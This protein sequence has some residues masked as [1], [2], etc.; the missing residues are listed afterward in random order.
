MGHKVSV[1]IAVATVTSSPTVVE[2]FITPSSPKPNSGIVDMSVVFSKIKLPSM[3]KIT[4]K[5]QPEKR[6]KNID[7]L[8]F[9]KRVE[10][11]ELFVRHR[12]L[13]RRKRRLR[14]VLRTQS[15]DGDHV[16]RTGKIKKW[17]RLDTTH[18][19]ISAA[20][21][22]QSA[23]A[24]DVA[25]L[26][27]MFGTN[28]NMLWGDLDN[29][30]ARR[31]YHT[32]L[33]RLLMGLYAQGLTTPD[34]LAP[35][36]YEAR[37][38]AK[39]YTRERS[40]VPG[41]VWA[42]AYDGFRHLKTYGNWSGNGLSWEELW[43]K[44]EDEVLEELQEGLS[45]LDNDEVDL[46]N[47]VCL[48]ILERSCITNSQIDDRF[49]KQNG[50][51]VTYGKKNPEEELLAI[52]SRFEKDINNLLE[53]N[54]EFQKETLSP[55]DFFFLRLFKRKLLMLRQHKDTSLSNN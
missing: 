41:R 22:R 55:R 2:S 28:R 32:L 12:E 50:D 4:R 26:R 51:P 16:A 6:K 27:S 5:E 45:D 14:D 53:R 23:C 7:I 25:T 35:L 30:T 44:Y 49:L 31:L 9:R 15:E 17:R 48:K 46:S 52:A 39:Q 43:V 21:L 40:Q 54:G 11:R 20:D 3:D 19:N 37:R 1:M 42:T 13:H 8:P 33:P 38:A 10:V 36:A 29:V 18:N 24:T 47:K 34:E